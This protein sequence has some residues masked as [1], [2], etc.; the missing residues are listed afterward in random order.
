VWL[1]AYTDRQN[2]SKVA[3]PLPRLLLLLLRIAAVVQV[4]FGVAFWTGHWYSFLN[5][6]R[7]VG[8]LFVALLWV[9]AFLALVAQRAKRLAIGALVLGA[10][11]LWVGLAQQFLLPGEHHWIVRTVHLLLGLSAIP[12]AERLSRVATAAFGAPAQER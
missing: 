8:F 6:H 10:L 9:I 12:I 5:A 4:V 2:R 7:D 11:I 1:R 3:M